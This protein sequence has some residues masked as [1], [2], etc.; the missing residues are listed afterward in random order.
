MLDILRACVVV[1]LPFVTE[2]WQIYVLAFVLNVFS[3]GFTPVLQATIP[4]IGLLALSMVVSAARAMQIVNTVVYVRT[5]LGLAEECVAIAFAA[6]G[7]G[8]RLVVFTL[9][10][11]LRRVQPRPLPPSRRASSARA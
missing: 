2:V 3:A 6:A 9:P 5:Y 4:D 11:L 1:V 10:G 8:S 7:G